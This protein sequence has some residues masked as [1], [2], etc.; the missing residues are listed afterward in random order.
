LSESFALVKHIGDINA[1]QWNTLAVGHPLVQHEFL[2]SMQESGCASNETGWSPHF[3]ALYR[4]K[5]LA[6][7]MPLYVK[8]HS[9]GEYVFDMAWARAFAQ[10][11]LQYYP[12]LLSAIP[13]T[14][15]PGPRLLAQ[16]HED[17]VLLAREAIALADQNELSSLHVLFPTQEDCAA[18][19]EAGF[20]FRESIQ[21]H[22]QNEGYQ[23]LDDFLSRLNQKSRKKL[24]QDKK[25][26]IEAGVTFRWLEGDDLNN[27]ALAFFYECYAR[28][29]F[30]H[31]NAPY[32]NKRFFE[33]LRDRM[34]H[35]LLIVMA[36]RDGERIACAL[37]VRSNDTLYGR[38]W[39]ST[40]FVSGLHFETCYM[41]AIEYCISKGIKS[42]EGG[43]QGEH[44][45]SRGMLPVRTY[46]AHWIRD[47]RYAQAIADFLKHETVA[48][49]GYA[50]ELIDH[51]PYKREGGG[52]H[53]NAA[54]LADAPAQGGNTT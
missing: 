26:T 16:S 23:N 13:F 29:Y 44:K 5:Q 19:R 7:A 14:P 30:A 35:N 52:R 51:S 50:D 10:H 6:G 15:V 45:L 11:G 8:Y 49:E 38:Y 48:I 47:T 2:L 21:F 40:Q 25:K 9:R 53:V 18:L 22:W 27:E 32:L 31:G 42:F 46:S 12:K 43:A 36:Y 34:A 37:N 17:R 28:T 33:Q 3:L 20:M 39:G 41:Q 54:T 4:S 24:R 1:E